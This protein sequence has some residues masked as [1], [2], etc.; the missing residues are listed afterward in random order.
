MLTENRI[1]KWWLA[2]DPVEQYIWWIISFCAMVAAGIGIVVLAAESA[3]A[4][5]LIPFLGAIGVF[6][7]FF[8]FIV[9]WLTVRYPSIRKKDS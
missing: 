6:V 5:T 4:A 2:L 3:Y 9:L 8:M 7:I 1:S